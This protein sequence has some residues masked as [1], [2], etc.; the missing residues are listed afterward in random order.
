[1]GVRRK[2]KLLI[3]IE[4][5]LE[6]SWQKLLETFGKNRLKPMFVHMQFFAVIMY[7]TKGG[8]SAPVV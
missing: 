3:Y 8:F 2:R 5:T 4:S 7:E 1:M 6:Y